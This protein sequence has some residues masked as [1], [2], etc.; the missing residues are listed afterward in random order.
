M[1]AGTSGVR[2]LTDEWADQLPVQDRRPRGRRAVRGPRAGQG[3]PSRPLQPVRHGRGRRRPGPTPAWRTPASSPSGSA[4]RIASGIGGVTTLLANYDTLLEKGP[5]R[6]SPLAV[7]MLMPNA[8][9]ANVSLKYGARAAVHAPISAC[10][11]G[12]EAI[13]HGDRPDP[14]RPRRRRHGRRHRGRDPPAADGG[15]RQHD[16]AVQDRQ[17]GGRRPD[18]R[19]APLGHRPRRLRARRGRRRAGP[20]VRGAR[21]GPRRQDLR[22]GARRRHQQRRPRHRPARPRGSRRHPRD[23]DGAARGRRRPRHRRARQR[24]RHLDAHRATSPRA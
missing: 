12:N 10:A 8:P 1:L 17:R 5:R 21:P 24:P 20:R 2:H 18:H 3:A 13:A 16:G 6:V 9:A 14:P 23:Q 15:V 11:S 4:S 22:R 19:L 7:P